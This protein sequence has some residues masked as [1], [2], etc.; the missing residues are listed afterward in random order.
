VAELKSK[1]ENAKPVD[2]SE[3]FKKQIEE[4]KNKNSQLYSDYETLKVVYL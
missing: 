3:E 2:N 4:L 1:A